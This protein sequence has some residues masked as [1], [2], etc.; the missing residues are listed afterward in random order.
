MAGVLCLVDCKHVLSHLNEVREEGTVNE[1]VQQACAA[2]F[3]SL[4]RMARSYM[5]AR[6]PSSPMCAWAY[7]A[8]WPRH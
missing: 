3:I 1:A 2:T 6:D 5:L 7:A 4:A 8:A